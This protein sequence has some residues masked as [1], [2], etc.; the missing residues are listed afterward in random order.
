VSRL[1]GCSHQSSTQT[2]RYRVETGPYL[3]NIGRHLASI[4]AISRT[5]NT[6]TTGLKCRR[7]LVADRLSSGRIAKSM[8]SSGR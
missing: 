4:G 2:E 8:R 7:S 6:S 3:P 1:D 5:K